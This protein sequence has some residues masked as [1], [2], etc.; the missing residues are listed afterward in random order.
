VDLHD[1]IVVGGG[2]AGC[3]IS[4]RFGEDPGAR[5]LVAAQHQPASE[6]RAAGPATPEVMKP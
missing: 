3:V 6:S 5:V 1:Y 2:V 4:N